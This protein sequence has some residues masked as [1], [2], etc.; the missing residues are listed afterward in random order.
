MLYR[1]FFSNT[2]KNLIYRIFKFFYGK[3]NSIIEPKDD[4]EIEEKK[5][6]INSSEYKVFFCKNS[7]LYADRIHD[8]AV[9]KDNKII[10]GPLFN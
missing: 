3:I 9:I 2:Y 8:A 10:E 5:I 7:S 4:T 6:K 1:K